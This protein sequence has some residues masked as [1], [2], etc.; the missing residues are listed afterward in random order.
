MSICCVAFHR[1]VVCSSR[2]ALF[3][4]KVDQGENRMENSKLLRARKH[5]GHRVHLENLESRALLSTTVAGVFDP[6]TI[7]A[8]AVSTVTPHAVAGS[9]LTISAATS[10]FGSAANASAT[11][12]GSI[13]L[14]NLGSKKA[15]G[16]V[17]VA[18][19]A[20]TSGVVTPSSPLLGRASATASLAL[21]GT[22]AVP[23]TLTLPQVA[24]VTHFTIV[25][26][27]VSESFVDAVA[28]NNQKIVSA[29]A[30]NP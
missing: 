25:A 8:A 16:T 24:A 18:F 4:R 5:G 2:A 14:K 11:V 21:N 15:T 26:R 19:Y 28:T 30:V 7:Q 22:T 27:I 1:Q 3:H 6:A 23:V 13:T 9:D 20:T 10:G 29:I 17:V 12:K